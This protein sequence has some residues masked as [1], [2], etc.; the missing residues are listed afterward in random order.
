MQA[1]P[2]KF[3]AIAVGAKTFKKEPV[4]KIESAEIVCEKSVKLLGIDIDFKLNF[5]QYVSNICRKGCPAA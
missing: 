5:E 3:Q 1:N 4:F 2:S